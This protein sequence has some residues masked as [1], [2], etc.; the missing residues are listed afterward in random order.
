MVRCFVFSGWWGL[1]VYNEDEKSKKRKRLD[2]GSILIQGKPLIDDNTMKSEADGLIEMLATRE[3][4]STYMYKKQR[5][6]QLDNNKHLLL[7]ERQ[8]RN[9]IAYTYTAQMILVLQHMIL[10]FK[11]LLPQLCVTNGFCRRCRCVQCC[12]LIDNTRIVCF[13]CRYRVGYSFGYLLLLNI[14]FTYKA[15]FLQIFS[16]VWIKVGLLS[17]SLLHFSVCLQLSLTSTSD[18][19]W[20]MSLILWNIGY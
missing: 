19:Q 3:Q 4:W 17:S 9:E 12:V 16:L 10:K 15:S 20:P 7:R 8:S 14:W 5:I 2:G 18:H 13:V 11:L 6:M 1:L